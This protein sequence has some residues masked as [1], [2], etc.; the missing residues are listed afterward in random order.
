MKY[1][2]ISNYPSFDMLSGYQGQ[3]AELDSIRVRE[4]M[5]NQELNIDKIQFTPPHLEST[6]LFTGIQVKQREPMQ[7]R[8][9]STEEFLNLFERKE[10]LKMAYIPHFITQCVVYYL[11]LLVAYAR[12]NRLSEYKKQTRRLK[13]IR[14]EYMDSL[15]KEMPP[16]VFQKFLPSAMNILKAAEAI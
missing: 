14:K 8:D 12:D 1:P 3:M 2:K 10:S 9:L 11:D 7:E 13:E 6:T 15:E 16:K 5:Q 4:M